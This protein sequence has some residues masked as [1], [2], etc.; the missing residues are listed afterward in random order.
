MTYI[1]LLLVLTARGLKVVELRPTGNSI[2]ARWVRIE[3]RKVETLPGGGASNT[4][5]DLIGEPVT[6]WQAHSEWDD[7]RAVSLHRNFGT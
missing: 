7:L 4:F 6:L 5:I 2:K 1:L 3:L